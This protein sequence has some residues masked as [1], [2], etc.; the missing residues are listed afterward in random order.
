MI[1]AR[2]TDRN[3]LAGRSP[4]ELAMYLRAHSW[5]IREH[6]DVSAYWTKTVDGEEYEALQPLESS[7][8]D[9]AL[10]VQDIV[11]VVAVVEGRSELDVLQDI[12][13]VS[14]DVHSVRTFPTDAAS[15]RLLAVLCGFDPLEP[16]RYPR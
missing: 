3:A 14:T 11:Q 7:L 8:R 15:G 5:V 13:N 1:D 2:V 10:R 6:D 16:S 4:S 12:S 9:Y